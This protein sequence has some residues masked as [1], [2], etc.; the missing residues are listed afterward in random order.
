MQRPWLALTVLAV[1][2]I[3]QAQ[4]APPTVEPARACASAKLEA[5]P[6]VKL[7]ALNATTWWVPAVA[8]E[9]DA[10]NRGHTSHLLLVAQGKRLWLV[11]AGPSP[12]FAQAL[13]C[14]TQRELGR[15]I[16]DVITPWAHAELALGASGLPQA[17]HWAHVDVVRAMRERCARCEAR[18][19]QRLDVRSDDLGPKP[20]RI[21]EHTFQGTSGQL[22]PLRWW[23]LWRDTSTAVTVFARGDAQRT[24]LTAHGLVWVG[25]APDLR[26]STVASMQLGLRALAALPPMQGAAPNS[27]KPLTLFGEQGPPEDVPVRA[28]D[29]HLAYLQALSLAVEQA[30]AQGT[31]GLTVPTSL[32][33]I[34]SH[35]TQS[36][37]HALNW[38]RAWRQAEDALLAPPKP[39]RP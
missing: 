9:S 8:S 16:T 32:P 27:F 4:A 7:T 5:W 23:R 33:S 37:Q 28:L 36:P 14:A 30:Q 25:A 19:R 21:P 31:D 3:G 2:W 17:R 39:L 22:G 38:Q 29:Q 15:P 1:A 12:A 26:D 34:P 6:T 18:M 35:L 13:T 10:A 20:V 24:V 11:G